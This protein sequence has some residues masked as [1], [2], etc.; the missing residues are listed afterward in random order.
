MKGTRRP[1]EWLSATLLAGLLVMAATGALFVYLAD[2]VGERAWLTRFDLSAAQFFH[3]YGA[4]WTVHL[5][6]TV[7]LFGNTFI[8]AMLGSAVALVLAALRRWSLLLGWSVALV[9]TGL[10]NASLKAVVRRL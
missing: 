6:E 2:E 10:L 1:R 3:R 5:L 4:R 7:T 8:L 9:G